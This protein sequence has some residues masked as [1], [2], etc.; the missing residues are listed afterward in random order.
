MLDLLDRIFLIENPF[1]S[2]TAAVAISNINKP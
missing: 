1:L 2:S